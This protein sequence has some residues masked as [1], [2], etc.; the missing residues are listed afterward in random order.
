MINLNKTIEGLI[1]NGTVEHIDGFI[2]FDDINL[3]LSDIFV[4]L[5]Y[6]YCHLTLFDVSVIINS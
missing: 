6:F 1:S 3:F 2:F 5:L 4:T